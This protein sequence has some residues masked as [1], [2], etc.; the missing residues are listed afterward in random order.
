MYVCECVGIIKNVCEYVCVFVRVCVCVCLRLR[1]CVVCTIYVIYR[2]C[3]I[4]T[5]CI[6]VCF[7]SV[8][9]VNILEVNQP[10]WPNFWRRFCTVPKVNGST[11]MISKTA[12]TV[13]SKLRFESSFSVWLDLS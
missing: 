11:I 3:D 4:L 5:V 2:H 1:V 8:N 7:N 6:A 12:L 9:D 10:P 13:N